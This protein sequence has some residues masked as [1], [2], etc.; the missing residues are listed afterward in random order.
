MP[1]IFN[2]ADAD[3]DFDDEK[4]GP[5]DYSYEPPECGDK[6]GRASLARAPKKGIMSRLFGD[7]TFL[8]LTEEDW[9]LL[10]VFLPAMKAAGVK[11]CVISYDGGSDEGFA[12]LGTCSTAAGEVLTRADLARHPAFTSAV[13]DFV[14]ALPVPFALASQ[15]RPSTADLVAD[16]LEFELPVTIASTLLGRGYGTGEYLLYGR[17]L[18]DL[19]AMTI[20]DDRDAPFPDG[21]SL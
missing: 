6:N 18:I 17:A 15:P 4:I 13:E 19:E 10:E 7:L 20:T 11:T 16:M 1:Y 5:A 12:M 9:Q 14:K 2:Y 3:E 21:P 8:E